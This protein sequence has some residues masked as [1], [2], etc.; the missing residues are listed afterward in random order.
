ANPELPVFIEI[1]DLTNS[2]TY[3]RQRFTV[4]PFALRV[5]VDGNTISFNS[6][7]KLSL[8]DGV[9]L[10]IG[11]T[12]DTVKIKAH[13]SSN[14]SLVYTLQA[15]PEDGKY[16]TTDASGNLSWLVA[17]G[18]GDMQASTWDS[19]TDGAIDIAKG[20]TGASTAAGAR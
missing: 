1:R 6:D 8:G 19:D 4:I 10:P 7:G 13:S 2:V 5:P 20:G 9:R 11:S 3:P 12:T 16:L 15:A 18:S 14:P 17:A